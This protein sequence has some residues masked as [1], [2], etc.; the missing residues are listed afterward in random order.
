MLDSQVKSLHSN[1]I[2]IKH[3]FVI[4]DDVIIIASARPILL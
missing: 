3:V 2:Q 4:S 1:I